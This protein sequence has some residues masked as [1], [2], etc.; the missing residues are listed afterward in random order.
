MYWQPFQAGSAI[1]FH[2]S[3]FLYRYPLHPGVKGKEEVMVKR[4]I[5]KM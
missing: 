1:H 2:K 3:T 5:V 4:L